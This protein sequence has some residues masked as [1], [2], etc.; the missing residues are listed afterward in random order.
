MAETLGDLDGQQ[1]R[2]LAQKGLLR[3]ALGTSFEI[4]RGFSVVAEAGVIPAKGATDTGAT[5]RLLYGF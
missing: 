5:V 3:L 4:G 1:T 2:K